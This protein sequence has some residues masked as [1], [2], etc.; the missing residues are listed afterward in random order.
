MA[1]VRRRIQCTSG[2]IHSHLDVHTLLII[3]MTPD[4]L[5]PAPLDF[6]GGERTLKVALTP[7]SG[8]KSPTSPVSPTSPSGYYTPPSDEVHTKHNSVFP[9]ADDQAIAAECSHDIQHSASPFEPILLVTVVDGQDEPEPLHQ[10][11]LK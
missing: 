2:S 11:D 1:N 3:A 9:I 7:G 4:H 5:K 6:Q 10:L 8:D